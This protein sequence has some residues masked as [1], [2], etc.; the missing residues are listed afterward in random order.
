MTPIGVTSG[1]RPPQIADH[2]KPEP[3]ESTMILDITETADGT[4]RV[5]VYDGATPAEMLATAVGS[6]A[7]GQWMVSGPEGQFALASA[8]QQ[9]AALPAGQT[10][11]ARPP[12]GQS[13]LER[14]TGS[15][16]RGLV[17]RILGIGDGR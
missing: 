2:A 17:A 6:G 5:R 1:R 10:Q 3:K 13:A 12:A 15:T 9:P 14:I 4:T 11:Q 7:T 16:S 8:P